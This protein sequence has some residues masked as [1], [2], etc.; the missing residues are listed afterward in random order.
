MINSNKYKFQSG[1][2]K[3]VVPPSEDVWVT[4]DNKIYL[5]ALL[6]TS[7][8]IDGVDFFFKFFQDMLLFKN[9]Q[10][11]KKLI[12]NNDISYQAILNYFKVPL[13]EKNNFGNL[14][15]INKDVSSFKEIIEMDSRFIF[16]CMG[17][18][19]KKVFKDDNLQGIKGSV[20][21]FKNTTNVKDYYGV[22]NYQNEKFSILST[23]KYNVLGVTKSYDKVDEKEDK[24]IMD[25]LLSR[26]KKFFQPKL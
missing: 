2:P 5:P 12:E 18:G 21:Y 20:I 15:V 1:F 13:S 14:K 7:Y 8:Q 4:F 24:L 26:A 16:N 9:P 23:P 17:L 3:G 22:E 25:D 6:D 19:S 11:N 10:E